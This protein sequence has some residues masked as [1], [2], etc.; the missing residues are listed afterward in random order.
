MH[1]GRKGSTG[2]E[3]GAVRAGGPSSEKGWVTR[4]RSQGAVRP[5]L[6]RVDEGATAGEVELRVS[7]SQLN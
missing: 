2:N 4:P 6:G 1:K 3:H 5:S 7:K